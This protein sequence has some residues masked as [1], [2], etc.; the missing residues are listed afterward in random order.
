[1]GAD[2]DNPTVLVNG[3]SF[4]LNGY[5]LNLTDNLLQGE[6]NIAKLFNNELGGSP[7]VGD[8]AT[9]NYHWLKPGDTPTPYVVRR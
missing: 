9:V 5:D 7:E 4:D 2:L 6:Q 1:M 3:N 8:F